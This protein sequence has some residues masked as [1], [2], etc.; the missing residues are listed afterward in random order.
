[1]N[2]TITMHVVPKADVLRALQEVRLHLTPALYQRALGIALNGT[3][4][5]E[6]TLI[7]ASEGEQQ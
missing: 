5:T 1:V 2:I 3:F 4:I 6:Q 7:I